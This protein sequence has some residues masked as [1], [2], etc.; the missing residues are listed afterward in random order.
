MKKFPVVML[1]GLKGSGKDA[2]AEHLVKNHSFHRL[3]YAD[4]L[5]KIALSILQP[6]GIKI[7]MDS[8]TDPAKKEEMLVDFD[9]KPF[10]FVAKSGTRTMTC[11]QFLQYLGTEWGREMIHNHMWILPVTNEIKKIKR[12]FKDGGVVITDVRFPNEYH[13][14]VDILKGQDIN[15]VTVLIDRPGLPNIDGHSSEVSMKDFPFNRRVIN[16]GTLEDLYR[17]AD[18]LVKEIGE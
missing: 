8:F 10:E 1:S 5:K 3:A 7:T 14:P 15:F 11:R 18:N 2:L 13:I 12:I 6:L 17:N 4:H 9:G 16:D